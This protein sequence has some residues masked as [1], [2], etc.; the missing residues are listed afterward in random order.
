VTSSEAH[1]APQILGARLHFKSTRGELWCPSVE[2]GGGDLILLSY[3]T[4]PA[5]DESLFGLMTSA[6]AL[7]PSATPIVTP[8]LR[9]GGGR[10]GQW[11][12]WRLWQGNTMPTE[13][14]SVTFRL[15]CALN[16]VG[17]IGR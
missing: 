16:A 15:H 1:A 11:V 6:P 12:R 4:A 14:W 10:V 2:F 17:P 5:K 8:V 9:S 13:T 3:E 7:Y